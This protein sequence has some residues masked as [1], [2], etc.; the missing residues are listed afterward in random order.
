M[1]ISLDTLK[2]LAL[3]FLGA[4]LAVLGNRQLPP[5]SSSAPTA[6]AIPA[7]P[8]PSPAPIPPNPTNQPEQA[9]GKL[10]LPNGY[11]SATCVSPPDAANQQLLLSASH[12][13]KGVGDV[14]TFYPK[15]GQ[16]V[17]ARVIAF[18][19]TADVILLKTTP[20]SS[21]LPFLNVAHTTP[22]VGTV[23][24]HAGYGVDKPNNRE[25]GKITKQDTGS[26]QV[27]FYLSVSPGDS[28]GGICLNQLNEV[29][30]PVCCTTNLAAPGSVYGG[31]PEVIQQMMQQ[32]A[33]FVG[34]PPM[35]MPMRSE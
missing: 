30:S 1:T 12:C 35:P 6:P 16:M 2:S 29:I 19:K 23:V 32:P 18:N 5:P 27:Q 24:W 10:V 17:S 15:S 33:A 13:V 25:E 3:A 28:G 11:C 14:V 21:P 4:L 20:V 9:I 8:S 34:V 31:R 26:Q 22:A 7:P